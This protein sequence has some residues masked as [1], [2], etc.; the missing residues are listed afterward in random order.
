MNSLV[1]QIYNI[2]WL[3]KI[4]I[5][6]FEDKYKIVQNGKDLTASYSLKELI[7]AIYKSNSFFAINQIPKEAFSEEFIKNYGIELI[8]YVGRIP[9]GYENSEY[10]FNYCKM[11]NK[12]EYLLQFK[13]MKFQVQIPDIIDRTTLNNILKQ[14]IDKIPMKHWIPTQY[15]NSILLF[16]YCINSK[17]YDLI[18]KFHGEEINKY[19]N[20]IVISDELATYILED[21][22]I[23]LCF[24]ENMSLLQQL[25]K[26]D[27][28]DII[29]NTMSPELITNEFLSKY[30]D[31]V[32][33]EL[34]WDIVKKRFYN[35][36]A[37]L[38]YILI[39]LKEDEY[40]E[41]ELDSFKVSTIIS[42][43][44]NYGDK[45]I[46]ILL[47]NNLVND[48]NFNYDTYSFI[49][50]LYSNEKFFEYILANNYKNMINYFDEKC[51]TDEIINTY[52]DE[53]VDMFVTNDIIELPIYLK[54]NRAILDKCLEKQAWLLAF[55]SNILNEQD[56][57]K[58]FDVI[59]KCFGV[60][61]DNGMIFNYLNSS[62]LL[63]TCLKK[64]EFRFIDYFGSNAFED[65]LIIPYFQDIINYYGIN[66]YNDK[67]ILSSSKFFKFCLDNNYYEIIN[68][69]KYTDSIENIIETNF[70]KITDICKMNVSKFFF[71]SSKILKYFVSKRMDDLIL[72]FKY[73]ALDGIGYSEEDNQCL[74]Y[75]V[76]LIGNKLPVEFTG[77]FRLFR[78]YIDKNDFSHIDEF[79]KYAFGD[80][81]LAELLNK[82]QEERK[83]LVSVLPKIMSNIA[84]KLPPG[85]KES[86]S[87]FDYCLDNNFLEF[88]LQFDFEYIVILYDKIP[89]LIEAIDTYNESNIPLSM[90]S[91][92]FLSKDIID[93]SIKNNRY[94]LLE[95]LPFGIETIEEIQNS[96]QGE[97]YEKVLGISKDVIYNKLKIYSEKND[98]VL[99]TILPFMLSKKME[100]FNESDMEKI[101]IYPDLQQKLY[102]L[103]E[104]TLVIISK[105]MSI[106]NNDK[107]DLTGVLVK[108]LNNINTYQ[109]LLDSIDI[110]NS[111]VEVIKKLI[112]IIQ[113]N[114]NI[115]KIESME[116]LLDTNLEYKID[117]YYKQI[118][119]KIRD[120]S[121]TLE[122]LKE[123]ILEKRFGLSLKDTEFLIERYCHD[124]NMLENSS[125]DKRIFNILNSINLVYSNDNLDE[126]K[127][128]YITSKRTIID[129]YTI[130]NLESSIRASYAK[131]YSDSLYKLKEEHRLSSNH[132][133]YNSNRKVYDLISDSKYK[134]IHP[135]IYVL[136]GDFNL[137]IHALGAYNDWSVPDNF[138]ED[139]ERP[140][141]AYHGICTSFIGNNQIA[142]ARCKHPIYG[143]SNYEDS[144]LLCA[145]NYDLFSDTVISSYDT[146]YRSPYKMYPPKEMIDNTRHTHN[147]M[148]L[149]R[150]NNTNGI[151][152]KR[153]P[154][155][156]VYIIDDI[157]NEKNF[158][159]DNQLYKEVL[160]ASIDQGV[161]IVVVD[162]LKYV[163][164][165]KIKCD[166]LIEEFFST[167][168]YKKLEEMV[169][170]YSNN[171]IGC[172]SF[173]NEV[174]EYNLIF[175]SIDFN[176]YIDNIILNVPD[177]FTKEEV[178]MIYQVLMNSVKKEIEKGS[179]ISSTHLE[180][181]FKKIT[182]SNI[183]DNS[184]S[185][186]SINRNLDKKNIITNF[187]YSQSDDIKQLIYNDIKNEIS[188]DEIIFKINNNKY[189]SE[190]FYDRGTVGYKR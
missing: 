112:L 63:E 97:L 119:N 123:S 87:V 40:K 141:I 99:N 168:N 138:K 139:W 53:L 98:E 167:K 3:S 10:L 47:A 52:K 131:M 91:S 132:E 2:N 12:N 173:N 18:N 61:K 153:L 120:N 84:Y 22:Y 49:N 183:F 76:S 159:E 189:V 163:K 75:I 175:S 118:E 190:G 154:D 20:N 152:F 86:Q 177:E 82:A 133:L 44:N 17:R 26:K 58:Y 157:N 43:L 171:M 150:R 102:K 37:I 67:S 148:V 14:I 109:N 116:D 164:R 95:Q 78:Y 162:R 54:N 5:V 106:I 146:G 122:E 100:C 25:V 128:L 113:K 50:N 101:I 80:K 19:A 174:K 13:N 115:Y 169:L 1:E 33:N 27:R 103:D 35:N 11:N 124:M 110:N 127:Y 85:M 149:E 93:Y 170:T 186:E 181:I 187:Y 71:E 73:W 57:E 81:P 60:Y 66:I 111:S 108:V 39:D 142:P 59:M 176:K 156:I 79:H 65:N 69:F 107:Y 184:F 83:Y 32:F 104:H 117:T 48:G 160:Q 114:K 165:E 188:E 96:T 136:D 126:L 30:V 51:Y 74:D 140:K 89:T 72:N 68:G 134:G 29:V 145:G 166:K 46:D 90:I 147:E 137:Q 77:S 178:F 125:I 31:K 135:N 144:A 56:F 129:F 4:E 6:K 42:C 23:P 15:E 158:Q 62:K 24:N 88:L 70:D 94:D 36:E 38:N 121:I 21:N 9:E 16:E 41:I 161:P 143:F 130:T 28:W 7:Y 8:E 155:Y 55:S 172:Q 45:I 92:D 180:D 185:N 105:I 151:S 64:G 34:E 182:N 179:A